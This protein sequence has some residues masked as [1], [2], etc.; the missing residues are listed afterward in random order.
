MLVLACGVAFL[1]SASNVLAF[2]FVPLALWLVWS[3]RDRST[4][5]IAGAFAT[6]LVLQALVAFESPG[7]QNHSSRL[8]DVPPLYAV[9]VLGSALFGDNGTR[10]L[11]IHGGYS[12][13][14]LEAILTAGAII[15]LALRTS[16]EPRALGL[17]T[18]A[19]SFVA[20]AIPVYVRGTELIRL[21]ADELTLSEARFAVF[22]ILLLLSGGFI[23]LGNATLAAT[24]HS[25][26]V[27]AVAMVFV[28]VAAIGF[29]DTNPRSD[30]PEWASVL[31]TAQESCRT[32]D[33]VDIVIPIA[34]SGWYVGLPCDRI[35]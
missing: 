25:R 31:R 15:F 22:S 21:T 32:E 2:L 4:Y 13:A 5:A 34:P 16:G 6:G 29:R 9:R 11:W 18:V 30:G 1:G 28:L 23:L 3:R 10:S 19:Y 26:V 17:V 20:F 27:A 12:S 33:R 24:V 35:S 8:Q 14:L 7:V